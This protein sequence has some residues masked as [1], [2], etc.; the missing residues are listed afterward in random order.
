M[1]ISDWSSDVCSS[2]LNNRLVDTTYPY[3][4]AHDWEDPYRAA[5]ILDVIDERDELTMAD[6]LALQNDI[7]SQA[8]VALLPLLLDTKPRDDR[9]RRALALLSRWNKDIGLETAAPP[10]GRA[11]GREE[12]W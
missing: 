8:A 4:I 3:A 2:D 11:P 9:R 10:A 1:R 5:R 12:G 6:N 7:V